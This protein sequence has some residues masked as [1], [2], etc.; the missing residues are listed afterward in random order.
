VV[1][2]QD[3][4]L[5]YDPNDTRALLDPIVHGAAD[6]VYGSRFLGK[7]VGMQMRNRIANCILTMAAFPIRHRPDRRGDRYKAS[8]SRY[9]A[10]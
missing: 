5:E 9:F 3:G 4:D 8:A 7:P 10:R 1:L 2:I 6:V